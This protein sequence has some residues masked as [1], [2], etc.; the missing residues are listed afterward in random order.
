MSYAMNGLGQAAT[1]PEAS[2]AEETGVPLPAIQAIRQVES[3]GN[4]RAVRFETRVF[5]NRAGQTV[6]GHDRAAF[7]RAY[8][9]NPLEAVNS[10][11]W[12]WFQVMGFH[13]FPEMYGGPAEAV[14]A[15]D[16]DPEAVGVRLFKRWMSSSGRAE[17][18]KAAARR[19]DFA[20]FASIYNGCSLA[21]GATHPCSTYQTRMR[22]A[23]ERALRGDL[24]VRRVAGEV[25]ETIT[26][27]PV[28]AGAGLALGVTV[29]GGGAAFAWWAYKRSM[30]RNRRR[31][32][33]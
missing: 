17:Q 29:L 33:S 20:T 25:A 9:I 2:L 4:P 7:Q 12:G 8:A 13:G 3:G 19:L 26:E 27:H 10:T 1:N 28:A 18:A 32:S 14:R 21:P 23:Y 31:R 16:A 15:F 6:E 11:S 24:T 5:R 22:A 30:K